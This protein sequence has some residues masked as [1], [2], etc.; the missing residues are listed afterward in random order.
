MA[1]K[2]T[3]KLPSTEAVNHIMTKAYN[4]PQNGCD[5]AKF[6]DAAIREVADF[7]SQMRS[8]VEGS[9]K[10]QASASSEGT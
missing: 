9:S 4:A 5:D 1:K 6:T 10:P 8:Q 2:P 3:I 7:F